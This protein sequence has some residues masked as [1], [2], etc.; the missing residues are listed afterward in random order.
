M[1]NFN[2]FGIKIPGILLPKEKKLDSWSVIA[3]DQYTQDMDY[4][5]KVSEAA[6]TNPS[7]LNLILPE[8][9]LGAPDR[10]ERLEKIRSS[11]RSYVEGNVFDEETEELVYVERTSAYGRKRKGLVCAIDLDTY[12]WKPF[13]KNLIRATEATIVDRIPPRKE[14][15]KNAPLELPH[16]MLLV[17]DSDH[18]LVEA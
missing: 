9:Y 13:S 5:N 15:R 12:G 1:R 3:C 14:I 4:W 11:M 17:N 8:V 7:T 18:I 2:K 16:I 10:K 6:G